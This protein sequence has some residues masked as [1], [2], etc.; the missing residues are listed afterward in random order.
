MNYNA[1]RQ[2]DW[3]WVGGVQSTSASFR[4]R[5]PTKEGTTR[6]F[7]VSTNLDLTFSGDRVLEET[8]EYNGSDG[9]YGMKNVHVSSLDTDTLYY[10][11]SL[12]GSENVVWNVGSFRTPVPE[13]SRMSFKV[14]T[15]GSSLTGSKS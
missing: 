7:V 15:S 5:I 3:F 4:V 6:K 8:L 11:G 10:F 2:Q 14:A 9:D 13:G 1:S 12:D